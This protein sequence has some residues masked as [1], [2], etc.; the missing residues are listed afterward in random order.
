[1]QHEHI[2]EGNNGLPEEGPCTRH[3][4]GHGRQRLRSPRQKNNCRSRKSNSR[5]RVKY[6][7]HPE[8]KWT[9]T[10]LTQTI[11]AAYRSEIL[12]RRLILP[13]TSAKGC[14]SNCVAAALPLPRS[15]TSRRTP[16]SAF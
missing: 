14:R 5:R 12:T 7:G 16:S 11:C 9:S 13:S 6:T 2:Y 1:E 8:K 3:S 15:K 10:R 4:G